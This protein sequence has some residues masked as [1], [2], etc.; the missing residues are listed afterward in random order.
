MRLAVRLDPACAMLVEAR[1]SVGEQPHALQHV[2]DDERLV[3][4]ELEVAGCPADADGDVVAH[5]LR[6]RS[7]SA[8]RIASD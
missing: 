2:V 1:H 6:R 3:D 5:H 8:P 7:S 4:V